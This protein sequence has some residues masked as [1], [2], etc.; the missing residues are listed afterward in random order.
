MQNKHCTGAH[1]GDYAS[2]EAAKNV[3]ITDPNCFG[4]Y[5]E[6]GMK[7]YLAAQRERVQFLAKEM[8]EP[9]IAFLNLGYLERTPNDLPLVLMWNRIVRE[10]DAYDKK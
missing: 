9:I 10:M 6:D 2:I 7:A 4:V 5:D 1:H 3:C 8:A